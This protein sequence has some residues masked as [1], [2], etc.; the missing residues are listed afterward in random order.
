MEEPVPFASFDYFVFLGLLLFARGADFLSTWVATPNL[1]LEGNPIAKKL[2][3][4]M[5]IVSNLGLCFG[6]AFLPLAAIIIATTSIL[7]AARNFQ[8]AWLMRTL[9]EEC[10]RQWYVAR[11]VESHKGLYIACLLAQT[12]LYS[13]VGGAL[14]IFTRQAVPFAIGLGIVGYALTVLLYTLLSVW[15]L[16]G[17]RAVS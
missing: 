1:V 17:R 4:K 6:F 11:L 16:R 12:G 2:G 15:K 7:V 14:M 13:I 5:G 8:S 3:W 10:Y 9:G